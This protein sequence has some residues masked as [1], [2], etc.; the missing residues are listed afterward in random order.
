MSYFVQLSGS[1]ATIKKKKEWF[2]RL[3]QRAF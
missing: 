1:K 3:K 2:Q